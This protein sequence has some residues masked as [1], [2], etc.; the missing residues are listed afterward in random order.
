MVSMEMILRHQR[1]APESRVLQARTDVAS[2]ADAFEFA[3]FESR[4]ATDGGRLGLR[5]FETTSSHFRG[6]Q[7][8]TN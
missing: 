3:V 6:T 2:K 7:Y 5:F 1:T 4:Q 8:D